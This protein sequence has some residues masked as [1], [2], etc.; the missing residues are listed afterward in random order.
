MKL[1]LISSICLATL[2]T[3]GQNMR[4]TS[5]ETTD[6]P[7]TKLPA[8]ESIT[9]DAFMVVAHFSC[10]D[11]KQQEIWN[12]F[13]GLQTTVTINGEVVKTEGFTE[14]TYLYSFQEEEGESYLMKP[15][16]RIDIPLEY[17]AFYYGRE[18]K[19]GE[20]KLG[21]VVKFGDDIL[22]SGELPF[23]VPDYKEP[24]GDFCD[25]NPDY[26]SGEQNVRDAIVKAFKQDFPSAELKKVWLPSSWL[27]NEDDS[28]ETTGRVLYNDGGDF[29][30]VT[31][32]VLKTGSDIQV[33][34]EMD[35]MRSY[36]NPDCVA[37]FLAG[38]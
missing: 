17:L 26:I 28:M 11:E 34:V 2:Q 31:Y 21:V 38:K 23:V 25:L 13:R 18:F 22:A 27:K 36:L 15:S 20:N 14:L 10:S 19:S 32:N 5:G 8:C 37:A 16:V 24:S 4:F 7:I 35:R 33:K 9:D 3:L 30:T 12:D 29:V 1:L 6:Q